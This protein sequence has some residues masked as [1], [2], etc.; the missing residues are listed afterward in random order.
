MLSVTSSGGPLVGPGFP[1]QVRA[2]TSSATAWRP[3]CF[4]GAQRLRR[5]GRSCVINFPARQRSMPRSTW[6]PCGRSLCRGKEVRDEGVTRSAR[7]VLEGTAECGFKLCIPGRLLQFVSY[8]EREG[9]SSITRELAV[10][11]A[12]QPKTAS[13]ANGRMGS[14]WCGLLPGTSR[15]GPGPRYPRKVSFPTAFI[16][17]APLSTRT[18]RLCA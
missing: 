14:A 4:A 15:S 7:R 3:G 16:A 12:T 11:W 6:Q 1:S 2:P 17:R 10:Q 5:S 18:K 13:R 8:A 9:A